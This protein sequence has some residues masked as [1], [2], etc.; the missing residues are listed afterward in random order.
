M[1]T[2]R[3]AAGP[4]AWRTG[5]RGKQ[6]Q[7]RPE[8]SHP[9]G[10]SAR[11]SGCRTKDAEVVGPQIAVSD[12]RQRDEPALG[13]QRHVTD[14]LQSQCEQK[15]VAA[16]TSVNEI[17]RQ[18]DFGLAGAAGDG[19]A[20]AEF[21][22]L[23]PGRQGGVDSAGDDDEV[24]L[25]RLRAAALRNRTTARPERSEGRPTLATLLRDEMRAQLH[26]VL[27]Q[28]LVEAHLGVRAS[29]GRAVAAVDRGDR[30]VRG[31]AR[32]AQ[33]P[34]PRAEAV[35]FDQALRVRGRQFDAHVRQ[36]MQQVRTDDAGAQVASARPF[37]QELLF[38]E[39]GDVQGEAALAGPAQELRGEDRTGRPGPDDGNA[40]AIAQPHIVVMAE[41]GLDLSRTANRRSWHDYGRGHRASRTLPRSRVSVE[42][43]LHHL[44][45]KAAFALGR[46][47]P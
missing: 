36:V 30:A 20:I 6:W 28:K 33:L 17:V 12:Q 7:S 44:A 37:A 21:H 5:I 22:R 4:E 14:A 40:R 15:D 9:G 45:L 8:Y 11:S 19:A 2:R 41:H 23:Q 1:T 13:H 47:G 35:P 46:P 31:G 18:R 34:G 43:A 39:E 26:G 27:E 10:I 24:G 29:R 16:E 32:H 25:Q 42:Q 3:S 38:I